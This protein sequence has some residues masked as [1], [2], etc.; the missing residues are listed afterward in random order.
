MSHVVF[1]SGRLALYNGHFSILIEGPLAFSNE[2]ITVLRRSIFV[3]ARHFSS[4]PKSAGV[5]RLRLAF[6]WFSLQTGARL[7]LLHLLE[8]LLTTWGYTRVRE[9]SSYHLIFMLLWNFLIDWYNLR[10]LSFFGIELYSCRLK[11]FR[12]NAGVLCSVRGSVIITLMAGSPFLLSSTHFWMMTDDGALWRLFFLLFFYRSSSMF[13]FLFWVLRF[14]DNAG[15]FI[16]KL[17]W[18]TPKYLSSYVDMR[19]VVV[20]QRL[21]RH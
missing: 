20:G 16:Y 17:Y 2:L 21:W 4:I 8:A 10:V 12:F 11:F 5:K 6:W 19:H 7:L 14:F 18:S 15:C 13:S 1:S 3:S 9:L